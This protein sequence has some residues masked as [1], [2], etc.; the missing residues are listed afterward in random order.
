MPNLS[1]VR[2]FSLLWISLALCVSAQGQ[3]RRGENN[4]GAESAGRRPLGRLVI[5]SAEPRLDDSILEIYG[6]N[7][8]RNAFEGTVILHLSELNAIELDVADFELFENGV[9][10]LVT[11]V[12]DGLEQFNGSY[13]LEIRDGNAITRQ[14]VFS[15][16]L[17]FIGPEGPSGPQ[18]LAGP[19][20]ATGPAG[21]QGPKGDPGDLGPEGPAGPQ[22][23]VGPTGAT[24]PVGP[25]GPKG[26]PGESGPEG[27]SG[28]QGLVGP[29][30]ATGPAGVA[31]PVGPQGP[32]GEQGSEGPIGPVGP[33]GLGV[34]AGTIV[35][36]WRT[37]APDGWLLCDGHAQIP[38]D[39]ELAQIVGGGT[40][41]DLRG[42]FLRGL[43]SRSFPADE[44]NRGPNDGFD[45][46]GP[47]RSIG[48]Q[49]NTAYAAHN[50]HL[51]SE[52]TV[53]HVPYESVAPD[54]HIASVV[55]RNDAAGSVKFSYG[56]IAA[57]G[58]NPG[59]GL[60]STT[61]TSELHSVESRPVNVAVNFIIKY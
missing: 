18:G 43:D 14:D 17:G 16:S 38:P 40:T 25:Q 57:R 45:P 33:A 26:D 48:H 29:T 20:G 13:L 27:P 53:D 11:E 61:G 47:S 50:H 60:S 28:P 1:Q 52:V 58:V 4:N 44:A 59:L 2:L 55:N 34:P 22:G 51:F 46:E 37:T 49:Q 7:F 5:A 6:R 21:P 19:T 15:L 30:G 31:G 23:L 36:T 35:A 10:K 42:M 32:Q 8:G 41:P 24:G 12:P 56:M 39:S 54:S 3:N 9:D